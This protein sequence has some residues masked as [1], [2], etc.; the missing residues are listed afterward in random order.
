[1]ACT[2]PELL[3][4]GQVTFYDHDF[5]LPQPLL[6]LSDLNQHPAVYILHVVLHDLPDAHAHH[7][8]LNLRLASSPEMRLIIVDHV[9][10]LACIDEGWTL[11]TV[12]AHFKGMHGTLAPVPLLPNL[13]KASA[14]PFSM[15]IMVCATIDYCLQGLTDG[16]HRCT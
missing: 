1:M 5:F 16:L 10:P 4:S 7:V 11:D 2:G 13:G 14:T 15:D 9:L 3:E 8:L 6:P 12:L